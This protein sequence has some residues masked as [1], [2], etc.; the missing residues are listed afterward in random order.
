MIGLRKFLVALL[1]GTLL[2]ITSCTQ[3]TASRFESAQ[4]AS[5]AKD[6]TAVVKDSESGSS[7]NRY[8]PGETGGYKRIYTQE[9][10]GFAQAKLTKDGREMA[11]LSIS[12]TLN[13]PSAI[14]KFKEST[15][16]ISSYPVVNQGSNTTA[17][18]VKDRF[19]VKVRSKDD[20][21]DEQD[22]RDWL[23]K[24]DL[25]GLSRL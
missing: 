8:F 14:D 1:L 20:S 15:D 19:Q 17:V 23:S 13:N 4:Q 9:K 6:A 25:R 3:Q 12:D 7:F 24:F 16:K 21:F 22:R 2:L 11:I 18:L 10:T 5:T